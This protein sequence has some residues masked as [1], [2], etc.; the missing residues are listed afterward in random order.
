M[1]RPAPDPIREPQA[2]QT[3]LLSLLGEDDPAEVQAATPRALRELVGTSGVKLR[4]RPAPREW[5]ALG[6]LAHLADA[7]LVMGARYRFILAHD[8]PSLIGYDQDMWVDRLHP[9]DEDPEPLLDLFEA[10]RT[11]NVRLWAATTAEDRARVG[12]HAERGAESLD[13]SFRMI[14]GHD[15][16]HLVQA[17]DALA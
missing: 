5:S 11:A 6:C 8:E 2:Y 4:R 3:Y 16:F 1:V 13:L 17:T 10:L 7:E 15:R 14:A 12:R 9:Q